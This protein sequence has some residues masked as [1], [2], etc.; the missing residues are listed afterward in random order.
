MPDTV[1]ELL[2]FFEKDRVYLEEV[3]F[4]LQIGR[5]EQSPDSDIR[6]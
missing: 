3:F 5:V 1:D 2:A 6:G 4:I